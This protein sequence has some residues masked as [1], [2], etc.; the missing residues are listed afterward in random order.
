MPIAQA[1]QRKE[2][3]PPLEW[4]QFFAV[5]GQWGLR[6]AVSDGDVT[7]GLGIFCFQMTQTLLA[8]VT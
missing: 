2:R 1:N 8:L 4:V 5:C 3:L 7:F 6:L